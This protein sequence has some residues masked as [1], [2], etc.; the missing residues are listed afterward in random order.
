VIKLTQSK[1]GLTVYISVQRI[2]ALLSTDDFTV[3]DLDRLSYS[4]KETVAEIMAMPEMVYA[5]YPAM[6]VKR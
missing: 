3:V 6:E 2:Q 4:V 5:M 1:D